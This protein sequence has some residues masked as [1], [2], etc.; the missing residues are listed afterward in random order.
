MAQL[1]KTEEW[2]DASVQTYKCSECDE[3]FASV[4]GC[5]YCPSCGAEFMSM[6]DRSA[7]AAIRNEPQRHTSEEL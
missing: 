4:G 3:S 2:H 5:D 7:S 1:I 6:I